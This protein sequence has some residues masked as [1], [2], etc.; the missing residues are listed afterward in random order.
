MKPCAVL[1]A[2]LLSGCAYH[3]APPLT[4]ATYV[5]M[6]SSFAAGPG[7]GATK[8]DTPARCSRSP[9]SYA[10]LT[11]DRL[12]MKLIDVSCGGA[13]TA[14]ILGPWNELPAQI[15]AVT[16]DARLV[17]ITIGGNDLGYVM[18]LFGASCDPAVGFTV[19]GRTMGCPPRRPPVAADYAR[20][21]GN[22]R[23]I[24]QQVAVRAPKA[25]I[26]FV[27]YLKLV[28]DAPCAAVQLSPEGA[29]ISRAIGDQLARLTA[30]VAVEEGAEVLPVD[31]LSRNHT[32]CDSDAWSVGPKPL[33]EGANAPWHPNRAGMAAISE[34]LAMFLER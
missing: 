21:E 19:E 14:H 1:A 5:A 10:S 15:D 22:L 20:L 34:A 30:K 12:G 7:L 13:T 8:P 26:V 29:L 9:L 6:G 23:T 2:M 28:P 16:A 4:G 18:N 32:A 24:V 33:G 3:G 27:Q 11:A 25:R 31:R 17:T